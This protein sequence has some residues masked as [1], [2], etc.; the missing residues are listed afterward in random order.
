MSLERQTG[1]S[2]ARQA[3][4]LPLIEVVAPEVIS[5]KGASSAS[6]IWYVGFREIQ[7]TSSRSLGC[8]IIELLT[9]KPPYAHILN[10]MAG[11]LLPLGSVHNFD[12]AFLQYF[13][14]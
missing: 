4:Q 11:L 10:S 14:A 6:D 9:G 5:L 2:P 13:I 1:V 12:V 3:L 7:L 8:T